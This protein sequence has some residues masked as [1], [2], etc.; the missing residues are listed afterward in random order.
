MGAESGFD[1]GGALGSVCGAL[2]YGAPGGTSA[3]TQELS[4]C[5]AEL[6]RRQGDVSLVVAVGIGVGAFLLGRY[7]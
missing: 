5:R 7:L 1:W 2:G 4:A 3:A 6:A